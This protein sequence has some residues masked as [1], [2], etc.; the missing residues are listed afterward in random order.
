MDGFGDSNVHGGRKTVVG[1]L[2]AIDMVV[3][4]NR[5]FAATPLARQLIGTTGQHFVGVHV[6]LRTTAGLPH[7]QWKLVIVFAAQHFICRLFDQ[8]CNVGRHIAVAIINPGRGL[9]DQH[10]RMQHRQ[11]H[12]LVADGEVDQRTL[13][14]RAPI[15]VL[16]HIHFTQAV[17]FDTAHQAAS[18]QNVITELRR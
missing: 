16:R 10:E 6:A 7:G 4:V 14:L 11:W 15:G 13:S 18:S 17:G 3:R 5:R 9:F 12:F 8:A 1:A 2:R